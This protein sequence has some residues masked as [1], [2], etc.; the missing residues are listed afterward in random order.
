M[1]E[2]IVV[3]ILRTK[4]TEIKFN[5]I[6]KML[7]VTTKP[8]EGIPVIEK[9]GVNRNWFYLKYLIDSDR[10]LHTRFSLDEICNAK[11][12]CID[13]FKD[14]PEFNKKEK[15]CIECYKPFWNSHLFG[16]TIQYSYELG[17]GIVLCT[18]CEDKK[19]NIK[20]QSDTEKD[21]KHEKI[22]FFEQRQKSSKIIEK[23]LLESILESENEK[24]GTENLEKVLEKEKKE[25][26]LLEL[27]FKQST[28]SVKVPSEKNVSSFLENI[29]KGLESGYFE[30]RKTVLEKQKD[31]NSILLENLEKEKKKKE[32]V[33]KKSWKQKEK[34][35]KI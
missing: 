12:K 4:F 5:V 28:S 26:E 35:K 14:F 11:H 16:K 19:K 21:K 18:T 8:E 17:D 20:G 34:R 13:Y 2:Y 1:S 23:E 25:R 9:K 30:N 24:K 10:G 33:L 31:E 7:D 22:F 3:F 27:K 29:E 15:L 32:K 6:E